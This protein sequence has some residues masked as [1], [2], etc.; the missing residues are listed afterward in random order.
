MSH[1]DA[2]LAEL[3]DKAGVLK[4]QPVAAEAVVA[5]AEEP[6]VEPAPV[7]AEPE[8]AKSFKVTDADGN[9]ME[10]VDGFE[11]IKSLRAELEAVRA[12]VAGMKAAAAPAVDADALTK[13]F[14]DGLAGVSGHTEEM[15]KALGATMDALAEA[16]GA[17]DA[18][19]TRMTAQDE[20][21]AAQDVLVKSLAADLAK[22]G[23]SG[24]GRASVVTVHEKQSPVAVQKAQPTMG[25][26]FAKAMELNKEGKLNA[27]EVS[28]VTASVNGGRGIPERFAHLFGA[29]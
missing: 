13:S 10:A 21:L 26:V 19:N 24:V 2:L 11:I 23:A 20:K 25:E 1:L 5:K 12:E 28:T 27:L 9:E 16:R 18:A 4:A 6:K 7:V 17:L 8:V 14:T 29:A 15:A 3:R 22:F